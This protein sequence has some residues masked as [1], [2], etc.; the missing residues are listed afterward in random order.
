MH[1]AEFSRPASCEELSKPISPI[2]EIVTIY[3]P[4]DISATARAKVVS[5]T[6]LFRKACEGPAGCKAHT[7]GWVLEDVDVPGQSE[8]GKAFVMLLGWDSIDAHN[9][10][11]KTPKV[12]EQVHLIAGLGQTSLTMHHVSLKQEAP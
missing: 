12:Q 8:K 4:V 7:A 5:D 6:E 1:H 3:F 2:T 9:N 10:C 11:V